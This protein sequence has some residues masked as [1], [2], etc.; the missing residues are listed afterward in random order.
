MIERHRC[1]MA[2]V[3]LI[4]LGRFFAQTKIVFTVQR[5]RRCESELSVAPRIGRATALL[6]GSSTCACLRESIQA[7]GDVNARS[8]FGRRN[9]VPSA[10]SK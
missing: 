8:P 10:I 3:W 9:K 1:T 6:P 5:L 2:G 7:V 4:W